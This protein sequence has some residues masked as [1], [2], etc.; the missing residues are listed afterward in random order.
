MS[1]RGCLI[2][3]FI[4][5]TA[6][7][8]VLLA[9]LISGPSGVNTTS[10]NLLEN[11][12]QSNNLMRLSISTGLPSAADQPS[13]T[14]K[15]SEIQSSFGQQAS[16]SSSKSKNLETA[17]KQSILSR[18]SKYFDSTDVD[19]K[20]EPKDEWVLNVSA[21]PAM[22]TV[23]L[24][25]KV[26]VNPQGKLDQYELA[27]SSTSEAETEF[28]LANFLATVFTPAKKGGKAVASS[29]EVEI[30]IEK[31]VDPYQQKTPTN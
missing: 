30:T 14:R 15:I 21:V 3:G 25:I 24:I 11:N 4:S 20:V 26:F 12:R 10:A 2:A 19:S 28:I 8:T 5:V 23:T 17:D 18:T 6:H 22:Q 27:Y 16:A 7:I 29:R 13:T 31:I 9:L 1:N